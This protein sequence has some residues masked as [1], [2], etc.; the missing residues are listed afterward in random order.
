MTDHWFQVWRLR[1]EYKK[2]PHLFIYVFAFFLLSDVRI[3]SLS[4]HEIA[5]T[6]RFTQ[7]LNT[8]STVISILL[9]NKVDFSFLENT[10]IALAQFIPSTIGTLGFWYIQRHWKIRAKKMVHELCGPSQP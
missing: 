8:T 4:H 3:S 1:K 6:L 10:Y 2:L 5:L 7:G 9:N